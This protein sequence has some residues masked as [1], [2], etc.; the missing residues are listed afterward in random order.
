MVARSAGV[1]LLVPAGVLAVLGAVHTS[2]D[3]LIG[4]VL[5]AAAA[6]VLVAL[7]APRSRPGAHG[8]D[9]LLGV[10]TAAL[11]VMACLAIAGLLAAFGGGFT[12]AVLILLVAAGLWAGNHYRPRHREKPV[13]RPDPHDVLAAVTLPASSVPVAGLTTEELCVAWRRSY[14]QVVL[15]PD[16]PARHQ[17]AQRRQDLLDELERR[18]RRGFLSWLD[19]GAR[20]G[21]DP[22]PYLTKRSRARPS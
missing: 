7:G 14:F 3:A 20:P 19:S 11:F 17:V 13:T 1:L 16:S 15:A 4:W 18:D 22:G 2:A 6:A 12:A 10:A 21:G 5:V 8:P 9:L